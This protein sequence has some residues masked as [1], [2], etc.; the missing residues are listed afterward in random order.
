MATKTKQR[1][2]GEAG[3][4]AAVQQL[5]AT[6]G[7]PCYRMNSGKLVMGKRGVVQLNPKGTP[8]LLA[9]PQRAQMCGT[10]LWIETKAPGKKPTV[11]QLEFKMWAERRGEHWLCVDDVQ[12]V[13][14]WLKEHGAI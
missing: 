14:D 11:E 13:I 3:V 9:S 1:G 10:Y 2:S 12:Q 6:Y 4:K 8:D 5:L 7:I